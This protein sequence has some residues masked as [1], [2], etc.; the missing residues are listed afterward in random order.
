MIPKKRDSKLQYFTEMTIGRA[1]FIEAD[2]NTLNI[3]QFLGNVM[4]FY[5]DVSTIQQYK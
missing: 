2:Y 5:T 4:Q 3:N 1:T